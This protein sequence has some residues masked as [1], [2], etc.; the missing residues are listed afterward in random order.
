MA[1]LDPEW[2]PGEWDGELWL[3]TGDLESQRT[4]AWRCRT[5]GCPIAASHHNGRCSGCRRALTGAG[6]PEEEFDRQ[7]R[8]RP[9]RPIER[10]ACSVAGCRGDLLCRGLCFRHERA[11]RRTTEPMQEF[12]ARAEP[13]ERLGPC[14]VAGC[15]RERVYQR[16]LCWFHNNRLRRQHHL[17][18]LSADDLAAWVSAEKPRIGAH[19]FSLAPLSELVRCEFLY[20]LQRRDETPPPLDPLQVRILVN[21]LVNR[22]VGADSLRQA[23]PEAICESGGVQYN[24]AIKS[25]FR[26]LRR[27]VERAWAAHTG[28]DP[29]AGDVWEVALLDLCSNGSRR[30]P[31][32]AGIVDFRPIELPWLRE[33]TKE[34]ARTTRP[35]LQRIREALRACRVASEVLVACG[36]SDPT[37][38]GA[39]DFARVLDALS[40]HRRTDGTLYSTSHRNLLSFSFCEVIEHGRTSGLMAEVPDPFRPAK[41]RHRLIE[42]ANEDQIG[43]ALPDSVIRQLDEHLNLLGPSGRFGSMSA[44][45]LKAMHQ[46]IYAI[47]RDTGRRPGEVVSLKIGCVEVIDGQHN[48]I[49]DNH[50]AGRLR[51]RL[52]ITAD[53]A[54][55]VLAWQQRRG[56]LSTPPSTSQWLFPSPMLRSHQ[57]LGHLTAACIG[58]AFRTWVRQIPRIDSELLGPD[59]T[60][61]AFDRSLIVPYALRHFVP[62]KSLCR[63]W[64]MEALSAGGLWPGHPRVVFGEGLRSAAHAC[65]LDLVLLPRFRVLGHRTAPIDPRGDAGFDRLRLGVRGRAGV[66][67][68][69]DGGESVAA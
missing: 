48:L 45:D 8:R 61:T 64:L 23:D 12:I 32:V 5:P 21:R 25:V 1:H 39:G 67:A 55:I 9:M 14:A 16:G 17:G 4:A 20:A 22:L 3:F 47:L 36:R 65:L 24:S 69:Y 31:A 56:Q 30:W 49:Y 28:A 52:P 41:R 62:A 38:L 51:R 53:T 15:G 58:V 35:Y 26:D 13:L 60:P 29:Y 59:G 42:D 68:L 54:E 2:R 46:S 34:W 50:K 18:S 33:V 40:G 27:Y 66:T 6:V 7:P 10:G 43:K 11:W 37:R 57:S 44:E 19:Q 63:D